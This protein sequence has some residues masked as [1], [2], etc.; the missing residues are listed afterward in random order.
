[1]SWSWYDQDMYFNRIA[2]VAVMKVGCGMAGAG[3]GRR[4]L[5][6]QGEDCGV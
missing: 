1:M 2:P 5:Q 4:P 3:E 6:S